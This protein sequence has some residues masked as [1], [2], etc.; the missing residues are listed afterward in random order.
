MIIP[1]GG[2]PYIIMPKD[3]TDYDA[4]S[5]EIQKLL[6]VTSATLDLAIGSVGVLLARAEH[7]FR[8]TYRR[9]THP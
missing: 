8:T 2:A 3:S 9:Q 6:D 7:T 4:A 1:V 5:P